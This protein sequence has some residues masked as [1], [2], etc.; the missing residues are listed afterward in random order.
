[1]GGGGWQITEKKKIGVCSD[2]AN[3]CPAVATTSKPLGILL[4]WRCWCDEQPESRLGISSAFCMCFLLYTSMLR[5]IDALL[6]V[7]GVPFWHGIRWVILVWRH[8]IQ[9]HHVSKFDP[10][11]VVD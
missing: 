11:F 10:A 1:M 5:G 6:E 2:K 7:E 4:G 9:K 8:E 3:I